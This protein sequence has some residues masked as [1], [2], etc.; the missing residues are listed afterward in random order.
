MSAYR[1]RAQGSY[2]PA[3]LTVKEMVDAQ[4]NGDVVRLAHELGRTRDVVCY[5]VGIIEGIA[6]RHPDVEDTAKKV[7]ALIRE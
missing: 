7:G 4:I 6:M 2:P 5:L 3:L 1:R